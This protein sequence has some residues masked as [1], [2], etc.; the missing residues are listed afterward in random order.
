MGKLVAIGLAVVFSGCAAGINS[1]QRNEYKAY[2][3][4]GYAVVEKNEGTASW[5]GILPGGGSFYTRNY[6]YGVINLLLWPV[7]ILWDPVSGSNGA[8]S[9]NYYATKA[10]VEQM[11]RKELRDLDEQLATQ[12]IDNS[13]Y[14]LIKNEIERKYEP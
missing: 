1:A 4:K 9:I 8:Q 11:R 7:S 10:N 2:E 6:G 3:A 12:K 13:R 5:M 14:I